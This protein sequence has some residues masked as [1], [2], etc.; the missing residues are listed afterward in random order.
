MIA[1]FDLRFG[2]VSTLHFVI[3][4]GK[5]LNVL[6]DTVETSIIDRLFDESGEF[7][8]FIR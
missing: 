7:D 4:I 2:A 5:S 8:D 1:R 6:N 3:F